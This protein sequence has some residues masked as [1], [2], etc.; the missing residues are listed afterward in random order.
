MHTRLSRYVDGRNDPDQDITSGLS[1]YLH[2]GHLSATRSFT[3][4]ARARA[5]SATCHGAAAARAPAGGAC[6][7]PP[8]RS[9]TSSSRGASWASTC[10]PT[11]QTTTATSRS[12]R[13][14]TRRWPRTPGTRGRTLYTHD[15]FEAAQ[16]TTRSGTRRNANSSARGASTTTCGCCGARR[17][18]SGRH[19]RGRAGDVMI[20][21]NNRY[22]LDGRDPN[23]YSGIFW[24]SAATTAP[25]APSGPIFGTVRYMSSENTARKMRV[26]LPRCTWSAT[27]GQNC[28]GACHRYIPSAARIA[29]D[30]T[31]IAYV[32]RRAAVRFLPP[33]GSG[34]GHGLRRRADH[35]RH[36][37]GDRTR[38]G[39]GTRR[40]HHRR[41]PHRERA[42]ARRRH[43]RR[44]CAARR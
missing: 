4:D 21:L 35:R 12:R 34:T 29:I 17:S 1:P 25:G 13:G 23:S 31:R 20:E 22:A 40:R 18:S 19:R 24:T 6:R 28:N 41:R 14:R 42:R 33:I 9:S 10:A 11:G 37:R 3:R 43:A 30:V 26:R 16:R 5:G 32:L 27:L 15:E 39:R 44:R 7:R 38:H 36:G 8:T 2:F